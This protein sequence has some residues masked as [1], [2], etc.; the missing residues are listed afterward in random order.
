[1]DIYHLPVRISMQLLWLLFYFEVYKNHK[2]WNTDKEPSNGVRVNH[3]WEKRLIE[4]GHLL[5]RER[6]Y[7]VAF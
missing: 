4:D 7:R 5:Q 1:M 3:F 2:Y 6:N